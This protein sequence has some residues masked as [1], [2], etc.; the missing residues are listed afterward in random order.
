M[1]RHS[2]T[3]TLGEI[4][5]NLGLLVSFLFTGAALLSG[6]NPWPGVILFGLSMVA[7]AAVRV[8]PKFPTF[9]ATVVI[10]VGLV[11]FFVSPFIWLAPGVLLIAAGICVAPEVPFES[12]YRLL[13]TDG[14]EP[15]KSGFSLTDRDSK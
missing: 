13:E 5:A 12:T 7:F 15:G 10:V 8:Y 4:G 11:G 9:S 2:K 6:V 1:T 14:F 3:E